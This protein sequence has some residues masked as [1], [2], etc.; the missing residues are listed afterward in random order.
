MFGIEY[1]KATPTTYVLHFKAGAVKR[2]GPG[3]SFLY[4]RP[5]STVVTVPLAS[6]DVPYVFNQVTRDFQAQKGLTVDGKIGPT[7]WSVAW[8]SP[9]TASRPTTR[10][11]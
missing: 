4:Y 6:S 3:L 2:E 7:T 11:T 9:T 1:L 8:T 10:S 5:T